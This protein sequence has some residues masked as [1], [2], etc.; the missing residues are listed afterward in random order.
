MATECS[1][2]LSQLRQKN[3][4]DQD[5]HGGGEDGERYCDYYDEVRVVKAIDWT[6]PMKKMTV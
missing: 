4:N 2:P 5:D 6:S 1:D 3:A